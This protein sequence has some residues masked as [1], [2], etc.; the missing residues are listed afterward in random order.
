MPNYYNYGNNHKD[1]EII[2]P[3]LK[4][5]SIPTIIINFLKNIEI[6]NIEKININDDDII[7]ND[8]FGVLEPDDEIH[9][10]IQKRSYII[11]KNLLK[12]INQNL[13][14]LSFNNNIMFDFNKEIKKIDICF[15]SRID[16][17][18]EN[19]INYLIRIKEKFNIE[20]IILNLLYCEK[21]ELN[22]LTK[23]HSLYKLII[24]NTDVTNFS[25]KINIYNRIIIII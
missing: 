15:D 10:L 11:N 12:S 4:I 14:E 13:I 7:N 21:E 8:N 19:I 23:K 2:N 25:E 1:F 22:I 9:D 5:M 17:N 20:E 3:Y 24:H 16:T 18:M 6:K